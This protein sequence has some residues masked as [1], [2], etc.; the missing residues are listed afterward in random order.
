MSAPNQNP[1]IASGLP[2]GAPSGLLRGSLLRLALLTASSLFAAQAGADTLHLLT[3]DGKLSSIS[4]TAPGSPSTPVTITGVT[5]GETLVGIDVRP[6]NQLLYALG[7][8]ATTDKATLYVVEP[9]TGFASV[10]G[11]ASQIAF[12]TNGVTAVDLPDPLTVKWGIDFNPAADRLRVVAGGLNFRVNPST[13][14]AVDGDNGGGVTTGTNPDAAINGSTTTVSAAAYTNNAP[15]STVTT[16]YTVDDASNSLF[17]QATPN[18]GTQSSPL[19]ITLSGSPLDIS[20]SS[21]DIAPGVN[22]AASGVAVTAGSGYLVSKVGGG[23]SQLYQVNLVNGV[24]TLLGNTGLSVRSAA[25]RPGLGAAVSLTAGGANL[26]RFDPTTPTTTT[27]IAVGALTAGETLVGIAARPQTGQLY[28]LGVNATANTATLYLVDPQTGGVTVVGVASSI[29]YVVSAV[30]VDLPDPAVAGYGM[31]FSPT[32]DRLR[33]VT[34]TGLNFRIN[35]NTGAPIDSDTVAAGTNP[36]TA[37]NGS[38]VTGLRSIAYTNNYAQNLT[39]GVTTLY[40]LDTVT[41]SLHIQSPPNAGTQ[42]NTLGVTLGG[43]PLTI[44]TFGGFDI[45]HSV[46]VTTSNTPATGEGLF[47]SQVGGVTSLYRLDLA[48]GKAI[49]AGTLGAGATPMSGLVVWSTAPNIVV[50]NPAGTEVADNASTL[51]FPNSLVGVPVTKTVTMRNTGSEPLNYTTSFSTGTS[52]SAVNGT[53]TVPGSS[54]VV[55]TLAF[56]PDSPGVKSDTLHILTNDPDLTSFEVALAGTGLIPQENDSLFA[57]TGDTRFNPLA[58]DTLEGDLIISAVSDPAIQIVDGR[59]LIIPAGY[60]GQFTY[61]I[62]SDGTDAGLATVTVVGAF[63]V[64]APRGFNGVLTDLSGK[65]IGWSQAK[66]NSKGVGSIKIVA[67]NANTSTRVTFPAGAS[68]INVGTTF[69]SLNLDRSTAGV[70]TF[71]L[72]GGAVTGTLHAEGLTNSTGTFH[73]GLGSIDPT[74][75]PGGGYATAT[76]SRSGAASFRGILPDGNSFTVSTT[77]TDNKALAFFTTNRTGVNPSGVIGGDLTLWSNVLTDVTGELVWSKPPQA[78]NAQGT[79]LG[80]VDTILLANGSFFKRNSVYP[81]GSVL[82]S[83]A[84]GN[85]VADENTITTITNGVPLLP[86]SLLSWSLNRGAGTVSFTVFDP[87]SGKPVRGS[88]LYLQKSDEF[89]GYFPGSTEGGRLFVTTKLPPP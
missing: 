54:S 23:T 6:Q 64:S 82:V 57:S 72:N 31:D 25:L 68:S 55:L 17:I 42:S 67:A 24:A 58:N 5:V 86:G 78:G 10:V 53:G 34:T 84:G 81:N 79:H 65:V 63:P 49:L 29:A 59:T 30:P 60:T 41:G 1:I 85:L 73:I 51:T 8:N 40:T 12:T 36:D 28:G 39:G 44:S 18:N 61:T 26:V 45:P 48:T 16:L 80:G 11:T 77:L 46:A 50:E 47:T 62:N 69:G 43:S 2:T 83:L 89:I 19:A 15:N 88:G 14:A 35:P 4:T 13:G 33:V 7:V 20:A 87:V 76:L 70:L 22:A 21:F 75:Y 32:V 38:G 56:T 66:L 27:T 37:I 52:F 3:D 9:S 74:T 71:S